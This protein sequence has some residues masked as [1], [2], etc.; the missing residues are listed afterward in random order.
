MA[1]T[2][3]V[4]S[5]LA[6]LACAAATVAVTACSHTNTA[7]GDATAASPTASTSTPA[8]PSSSGSPTSVASS[9][10]ASVRASGATDTDPVRFGKAFWKA[11]YGN[12]N[13]PRD[14]WWAAVEPMLAPAA[15]SVHVYDQ[16][17]TFKPVN[18]TGAFIEAKRAPDRPGV[19]AEV[20]VPTDQG[21]YS[22]FLSRASRSAPWRL[23]SIGFP[24][25][26]Q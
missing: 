10:P 2:R 7:A 1:P 17:Q 23:E 22:L 3:H 15:A 14:Q 12:D 8:S 24:K 25:G 4:S 5:L 9:A 21:R 13:L 11:F 20:Y 26:A 18:V 6:G 16:P 19:T